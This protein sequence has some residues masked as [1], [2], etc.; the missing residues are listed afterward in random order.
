M[1]KKKILSYTV[2]FILF[3]GILF[4]SYNLFFTPAKKKQESRRQILWIYN[5]LELG[6][7]KTDVKNFCKVKTENNSLLKLYNNNSDKWIVHSPSEFGATNW[8]L[9]LEFSSDLLVSVKIRLA[10]S[11]RF[12]PQDSPPDKTLEQKDKNG[13]SR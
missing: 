13:G 3:I 1:T 7:T 10:D 5:N 8:V 12:K 4:V 9:W 11:E 2:N 6:K